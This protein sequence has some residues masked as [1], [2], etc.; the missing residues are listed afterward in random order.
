M[1][2]ILALALAG[3][4]LVA[5]AESVIYG[6]IKAGLENDRVSG[7]YGEIYDKDHNS[8]GFGRYDL[9]STTRVE[10]YGS[11][12]G[13]KGS[14]EISSGL[15]G[16]WQL[17]LGLDVDS[18]KDGDDTAHITLRD[19]FVGLGGGFG[20]VRLGR[21]S[22]VFNDNATATGKFGKVDFWEYGG[23]ANGLNMYGRTSDR[24]DNSIRY[25]SPNWGGFS[26]AVQYGFDE[27][28][29][30]RNTSVDGEAVP[31]SEYK[32][33]DRKSLLGVGLSY[34]HG[35]GFFGGLA[36]ER[37]KAFSNHRPDGS[38]PS[39]YRSR[40]ELGY[41]A[42]NFLVAF[43]YQMAKDSGYDLL[44][45]YG[46]DADGAGLIK[47]REAALTLGYRMGAFMPKLTFAKGWDGKFAH[48][49]VDEDS[50]IYGSGYKQWIVGAD[51]DLS[52]RTVLGASYGQLK[53]NSVSRDEF[54]DYTGDGDAVDNRYA[55]SKQ[56]TFGI[57]VVHRF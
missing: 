27:K 48:H 28:Q 2:K 40:I 15:R 50:R 24:L 37:G 31:E 22:N 55:G 32:T 16:I 13:F 57:N 10:D 18:V 17:E 54:G 25:D 42:N 6:A 26:F 51:Y 8:L 30:H 36:Y 5:S 4:P 20:T 41:D 1:K 52:R 3:L 47:T 7:R 33:H 11:R 46:D 53:Y 44:D 49:E 21:I 45:R 14:E 12:I 23:G 9:R 35:S 34:A 38:L 29:S 43:G 19:S 39:A 56:R